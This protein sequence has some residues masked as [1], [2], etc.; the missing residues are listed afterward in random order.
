MNESRSAAA[1]AANW[2]G[3]LVVAAAILKLPLLWTFLRLGAI[4]PAAGTNLL[5]YLA[6]VVL[7]LLAGGTGLILGRWFGFWCVYVAVLASLYLGQADLA[8]GAGVFPLIDRVLPP[9]PLKPYWLWLL[10]LPFLALL[11]WAHVRLRRERGLPPWPRLRLLAVGAAVAAF[12]AGGLWLKRFS[13]IHGSYPQLA[14]LPAVGD[15]LAA[16]VTTGPVEAEGLVHPQFRGATAVA[17]G[18]AE[19]GAVE[20]FAAKL[21]MKPLHDRPETWPKMLPQCRQWALAEPRFARDFGT[22]ALRWL[23]RVG[24]DRKA[25]LQLCWRPEDGR[26]TLEVL[27]RVE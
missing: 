2:L 26:F 25:A 15:D 5:L 1:T 23:G 21:E 9:G 7:L 20:S 8:R 18:R 19:R 3:W 12:A 10:N 17:S 16:L 14:A 27:G 13:R 6:P 22:N 11:V 24:P 4:A